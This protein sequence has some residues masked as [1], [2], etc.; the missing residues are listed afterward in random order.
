MP[1]TSTHPRVRVGISACLLGADVRHDGGTVRAPAPVRDLGDHVEWVPVC[2]EVEI[3]LGVPRPAVRLVRGEGGDARLVEP[4]ADDDLSGRTDA[5]AARWL[6]AT[7]ELDGLVLKKNSPSCGLERVKVY[8]ANGAPARDGVGRFTQSVLTRRPN[9]PVEEEGRLNDPELRAAYLTAVWAHGRL[10]TLKAGGRDPGGLVAFHTAEK[11]LVMAHSPD[12]YRRLGRLVAEAGRDG[13]DERLDA[14]ETLFM[15][16]VRI[17]P[18]RGRTV[19]ALQHVAGMLRE[20]V[21]DV[22][23]GEVHALVDEYAAGLVP[24][25]A[26][27]TLIGYLVRRADVPAWLTVQTWLDPY[28]R[29]LRPVVL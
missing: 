4:R 9:L 14:Y 5:F 7:D 11:L 2:P 6:D 8:D 18:R 3:G 24:L 12:H 15:E 27:L 16:A 22:D 29:H 10:R 1:A 28:P 13:W 25:T 19:N 23:R 26:P 17:P 21:D 20:A